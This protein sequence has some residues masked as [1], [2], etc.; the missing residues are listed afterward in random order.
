MEGNN[1][2]DVEEMA[3]VRTV[4]DPTAVATPFAVPITQGLIDQATAA[5][6]LAPAFRSI[7]IR[8]TNPTDWVLL[9]NKMYPQDGACM[10][11]AGAAG[12]S[13][14]G[15]KIEMEQ[16]RDERG[17]VVAY[18]ATVTASFRGRSMEEEGSASTA[19]A[20]FNGTEA[21]EDGVKRSKR[22]PLSEINVGNVRKKAVTNA[23][24]R[25]TR[26][27]LGIY[28]STEEV[29]AAFGSAGGT[30]A[31]VSYGGKSAPAAG[32]GTM[33]TCKA[34]I[35]NWILAIV[36]GDREAAGGMLERLTEFT[37][38]DGKS[39]K[40]VRSIADLSDRRAEV[41]HHKV[42][43]LYAKHMEQLKGNGSKTEEIK[44]PFD[45]ESM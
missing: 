42:K 41:T 31:A 14:S 13:Y 28:Y 29:Q 44:L 18:H 2:L 23:K 40:G 16:Y 27:L 8:S 37:A 5:L 36:E 4:S 3:I 30:V 38:K 10:K 34:E 12:V 6:A 32:K 20:F 39:V 43:E 26:K 11:I 19:D 35:G 45:S 15:G 7:L 24:G 17:P 9:G 22:L 21:G 25:A 33:N 1:D